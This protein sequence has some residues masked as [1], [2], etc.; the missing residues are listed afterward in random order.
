MAS[1]PIRPRWEWRIFE[2]FPARFIGTLGPR[3]DADSSSEL[4]LL[5]AR[6]PHNTKIRGGQLDVKLLECVGQNGLELWR[7]VFKRPFPIAAE[8]LGP[9]WKAWGI[10]AA[11][12]TRA[13][14]TLDEFLVDIVSPLRDV[15]RAVSVVK[16]RSKLTQLACQ[17]ERA[18]LTLGDDQWETFA[19]EDEDPARILTAQRSLGAALPRGSNYPA[20]LKGLVGMSDTS[21]PSARVYI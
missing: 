16:A 15:V 6:S 19:L 3:A 11:A 4:Y 17:A 21:I 1:P 18:L 8:E 12:T 14:Y 10:P 2:R 9:V 13:V 20:W 7:P 5:S